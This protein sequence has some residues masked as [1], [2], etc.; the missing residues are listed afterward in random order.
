MKNEKTYKIEKIVTEILKTFDVNKFEWEQV[1][2]EINLAFEDVTE[3]ITLPKRKEE[4]SLTSNLSVETGD[5]L[6]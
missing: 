1:V 4:V 3:T 6:F 2:K 5:I